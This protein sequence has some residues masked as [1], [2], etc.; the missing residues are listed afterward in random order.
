VRRASLLAHSLAQPAS[1]GVQPLANGL[2][3]FRLPR[4]ENIGNSTE[5]PLHLG[6]GLEDPRHAVL[7]IPSMI[8]RLYCGK[9]ACAGGTP[10]R[11][12]QREKQR[13]EKN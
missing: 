1:H 6:L 12:N 8:R 5:A 4:T 11:P 9:R 7:H 2:V 3:K 10:E 13:D